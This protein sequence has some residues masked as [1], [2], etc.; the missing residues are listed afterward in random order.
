MSEQ[1]QQKRNY[2]DTLNLPKT[3]FDMRAGLKKK[4]PIIQ[5]RWR[6]ENLYGRMLQAREGS[7][8]FVLHDGPP[9]ANGNI[10]M[11]TA[12]NKVLKD[13]V[14][15][16]RCMNGYHTPYIPGWDCHGL[17]IEAKVADELGEQA[18]NMTALDIRQRCREYAQKFVDIQSEQL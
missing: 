10:H 18:R 11:G 13:I 7:E 16:T 6:K 5:D 17:P 14:V 12:L 3:S 1:Q 4:E 8:T 15:R 2:K 9:Y